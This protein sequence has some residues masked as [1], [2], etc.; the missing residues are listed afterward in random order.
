MTSLEDNLTFP[1]TPAGDVATGRRRIA[2]MFGAMG[3]AS[4]FGA[5]MAFRTRQIFA[6]FLA[7]AIAIGVFVIY[8]M[9]REL[10][11]AKIVVEGDMLTIWMRRAIRKMPLDGAKVRA[12]TGD[13]ID[14]L[15]GLAS[16]GGFT[17][18]SG[19]FDSHL[20]G[21]FDLYASRFENSVLVETEDGRAVVTPDEP[22]EFVT[23]VSKRT[24]SI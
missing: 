19:G 11:P 10:N 5:L 14:H 1:C 13:E 12:L 2:W 8:Q 24:T 16:S 22:A 18:G 15:I 21:E 6:G 20:L 4:L 7:L 17:A 23:A 9:S 3:A